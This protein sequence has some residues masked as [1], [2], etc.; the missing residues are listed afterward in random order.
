MLQVY[1]KP[2]S[3]NKQTVNFGYTVI[4]LFSGEKNDKYIMFET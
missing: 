3:L 1:K 2:P 4:K